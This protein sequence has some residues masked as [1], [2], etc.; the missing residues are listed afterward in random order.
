M[1][2]DCLKVTVNISVSPII[3][4]TVIGFAQSWQGVVVPSGESSPL[5]F[6]PH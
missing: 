6:Y 2:S 5:Q 4:L 1:S 3:S